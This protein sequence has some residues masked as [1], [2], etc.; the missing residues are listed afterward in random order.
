M[1]HFSC[2][3]APASPA[4]PLSPPDVHLSSDVAEEVSFDMYTEVERSAKYG[5]GDGGD[6]DGGEGEGEGEGEGSTHGGS[7][8]AAAL[9]DREQEE[10][11]LGEGERDELAR[12]R[13]I[14]ELSLAPGRERTVYVCYRPA[15]GASG[16]DCGLQSHRL[17]RRV[18]RL[19]LKGRPSQVGRE[20]GAGGAGGR[21]GNAVQYARCVQ[22]RARVCT[23]A[24]KVTHG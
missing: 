21:G 13:R 9:H 7:A 4:H 22:C 10:E 14:E 2:Y 11:G 5:S 1:P 23:S 12:M 19:D 20:G 6:G 8:V 16:K 17:A 18:F 15:V 24:V 3:T